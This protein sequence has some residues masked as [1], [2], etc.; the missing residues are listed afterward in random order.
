VLIDVRILDKSE[1]LDLNSL[2]NT[3]LK[4][5]EHCGAIT[6]FIGLVKGLVE[7]DKKVYELE[8]TI[9][10]NV[11]LKIMEKIAREEAEKYKLSHVVIWHRIGSLKPGEVTIVIAVL[12]ENRKSS[13]A[14]AEEILE[15]VKSEVPIF[16]LEKR[17]DG[18]YWVIGSELRV[19]REK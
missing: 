16:K 8:Y 17:S 2:V 19:K 14:A 5:D 11:A 18:E 1:Q 13:F 10:K 15:R 9:V 4:L 6:L 12:A 3:M 7:G